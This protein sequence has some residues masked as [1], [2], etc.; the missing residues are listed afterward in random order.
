[1]AFGGFNRAEIAAAGA[2]VAYVELT[3]KGKLPRLSPPRRIASGAVMEI[4]AGTRRNLELVRTLSGER[5]GSLLAT[6]DRTVTGAGARA[7]AAWL[8]APL[9]DPAAIAGRHDMVGFFAD[10]ERLR[11]ELR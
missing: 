5:Q 2:L 9:T 6:I 10:A 4:D 3:Q 8:A 7:L 11:I 1:D